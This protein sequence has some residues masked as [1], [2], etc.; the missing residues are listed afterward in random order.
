MSVNVVLKSVWD[1]RGIQAAQ[2]SLV[3]FS[4][5]IGT[6]V[7]AVS[8]ATIAAGIGITKFSIEAAKSGSNLSES[9]NAVKVSYGSAADE[10]IKLGETAAQ[11]LGV[12]QTEFNAATVRFS[13]FAERIVGDGGNVAGFIDQITTRATDFASVFN[14]DVAE[15]LQVFQSGLSGEAEPLK[16]FGINLLDSEVKAYAMANGIGKVGKELTETEKVQARYGLLLQ[17]TSKVQGDFANTSEGLANRQRILQASF[18]DLE[19]QIGIALLPAFEDIL[20][21]V[22]DDLFPIFQD[23][24]KKAGPALADAFQFI[25]E[26]I[27]EAFTEGTDLN[28]ALRDLGGAF[29]LL[30]T[31]VTNGQRDAKGFADWL[32][33][34]VR[35]IEFVTTTLASVIAG[36]QGIGYAFDAL[37]GGDLATFW[38]F[39]TTDTI[40]FASS[41]EDAEGA[42][43]GLNNV[44]LSKFRS[45]LGDIRID[46]EKIANQQRE[47][48][49]YMNG[50]KPGTYKAPSTSG[51]G[52]G[53]GSGSGGGGGKSAAEIQAEQFKKVQGIIKQASDKMWDAQKRYQD[54]VSDAQKDFA[55]T[56]A[57]IAEQYSTAVY[58]ATIKKNADLEDALIKHNEK[59]NSIQQ[60]AQNKL[61]DIVA[62]SK[63]GLTDAYYQATALTL[64]DVFKQFN[65]AEKERRKL[66]DDAKKDAEKDKK[67]FTDVFT[68]A[69]PIAALRTTLANQVASNKKL[70][71]Q[72]AALFGAGFSQTFIEQMI[73]AGDDGGMA[74][75]DALLNASPETRASIQSLFAEIE[76]QSKTGL[77]SLAD[78]IYKTAGLATQELKNL[79]AITE[80]ELVVSLEAQ[81]VAYENQ[82]EAIN[83]VFNDTIVKATQARNKAIADATLALNEALLDAASDLGD[84]LAK[85]DKEFRDT[86]EGLDGE[87]AGLGGTIQALLSKLTGLQIGAA[88]AEAG[89]KAAV[90]LPPSAYNKIIAPA[91]EPFDIDFALGQAPGTYAASQAQGP[92][93]N[94]VINVNVATD[95]TQSPAMVGKAVGNVI[96]KY[97]TTGGRVAV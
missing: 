20:G 13:A 87:L 6:A 53:A 34:L 91:P 63:K 61:A 97:V 78:Q 93:S 35:V 33:N 4:K 51:G 45:Q 57:N 21:V 11:R 90:A 8:A 65:D 54:R 43:K 68:E 2:N 94:T 73:S 42:V 12:T 67:V 76:T 1:D 15:A 3:G 60:D 79:Y 19:A 9:L 84:A 49:Y 85:I 88:A 56:S 77:D 27:G 7:A 69:D 66:F 31:S 50:G 10:I 52:A 25:A 46:G 74:I 47:L 22:Q 48:A 92:V 59:I 72:S 62:D 96:T 16:R 26:V 14:I 83:N 32:S 36:F 40:N 64:S 38:K 86:I 80:A 18:K 70:A 58:E 89:A 71:E 28:I 39:L 75:T 5:G 17:S 37:K 95:P 82:V 41:I 55:K 81:Q 29:D 30:F 44:D 23:M 24:A